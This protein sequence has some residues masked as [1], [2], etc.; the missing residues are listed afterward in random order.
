M[1]RSIIGEMTGALA[2]WNACCYEGLNAE[3]IS[4]H[5]RITKIMATNVAKISGKNSGDHHDKTA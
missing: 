2:E 5:N 4:E 3:E 1:G